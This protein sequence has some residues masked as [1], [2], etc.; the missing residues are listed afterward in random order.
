MSNTEREGVSTVQLIISQKLGWIFREQPVEDYGI[1]AHIEVRGNSYPTGKLIGVQIKS[2]NSYFKKNNKQEVVFRFNA[3]HCK[4]WLSCTFKVILVLYS[5]HTHECIWEVIQPENISQT[6]SGHYSI[7]ISQNNRLCKES[8]NKLILIAYQ[9]NIKEIADSVEELFNSPDE[10]RSF[11]DELSENGKVIFRDGI[12]AFSSKNISL[13]GIPLPLSDDSLPFLRYALSAITIETPNSDTIGEARRESYKNTLSLVQDYITSNA[14][15]PLVIIGDSGMGK[16]YLSQKIFDEHQQRSIYIKGKYFHDLDYHTLN[17]MYDFGTKTILIFDGWDEISPNCRN[18]AQHFLSKIKDFQHIKII[19]TSRYIPDYQF[20]HKEI[21]LVPLSKDEIIDYLKA[22]GISEDIESFS[23]LPLFNTPALLNLLIQF[24]RD[25]NFHPNELTEENI[26]MCYYRLCPKAKHNKLKDLAFEM[27]LNGSSNLTISQTVCESFENSPEVVI[28]NETIQFSHKFFYEFYLAV[29]IFE[30]IFLMESP[31][32]AERIAYLFSHDTPSVEVFLLVKTMIKMARFER[33]KLD[34]IF[35][36]LISVLG[37]GCPTNNSTKCLDFKVVSNIFYTTWHIL[38][39]IKKL[40]DSKLCINSSDRIL[41]ML[42]YYINIF[43]KDYFSTKFL[44][45]SDVIID[46]LK[47]WRCNAANMNFKNA[48]L[49]H[50]NFRASNLHG[51]TF[52]NADLTQANF[53]YADLRH[54]CLKNATL[55]SCKVAHCIISQDSIQDLIKYRNSLK[56]L[57]SL[58]I[59]LDTGEYM[60]YSQYSSFHDIGSSVEISNY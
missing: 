19:V 9:G 32:M 51:T 41:D 60:T 17:K 25:H 58:V 20:P 16:S 4:Y 50:A 24:I 55:E 35:S 7:K 54:T 2:G 47:L 30:E 42:P 39:Y 57:E 33:T 37:D 43:N 36:D 44:D 29:K 12:C 1:D 13:C 11:Y 40:S 46:N 5:P 22:R 59:K 45:F 15:D 53:C 34:H 3:Q 10:I 28:S 23:Y 14:V 18:Y 21:H 8:K 26:V 6:P 31:N 52:E 49:H 27:Y 56:G 48:V 38:L